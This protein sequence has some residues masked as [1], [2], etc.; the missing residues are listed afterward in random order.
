MHGGARHAP[1]RLAIDRVE[2]RRIPVRVGG[3]EA[4]NLHV[5]E[6]ADWSWWEEQS[7]SE[8]AN[9][10]GAKLWP[11]SLAVADY[12]AG[13]PADVLP[14][15]T[16]LEIGCGNGLCSLT[17]AARG[18]ASVVASDL[19]EDALTLTQEAAQQQGL[20]VQTLRFDLADRATPLPPAQLVIAADVLCARARFEPKRVRAAEL[21]CTTC[22]ADDAS[23]AT[24]VAHRVAEAAARGSWV[25]VGDQ[26]R[27]GRQAFE[28]TLGKLSA[29]RMFR[30]EQSTAVQ[31]AA[32]GWKKKDVDLMLINPPEGS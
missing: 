27:A 17:A 8:S 13:L 16:V 3:N 21:A 9:P 5:V 12:L 15:T 4:L 23:L 30:F 25:V 28:R 24:A 6:V 26:R 14:A 32:V 19:S 2:R 1:A 31:L 11:A 20:A 7:V 22:R 10:F 18:A 29:P